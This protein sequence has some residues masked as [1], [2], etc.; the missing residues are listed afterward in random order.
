MQGML[1]SNPNGHTAKERYKVR[2][3]SPNEPIAN[4]RDT[5]N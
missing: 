4:E 5:I 1:Q 2:H 3:K